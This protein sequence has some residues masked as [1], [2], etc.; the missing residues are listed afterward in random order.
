MQQA[1]QLHVCGTNATASTLPNPAHCSSTASDECV[2]RQ[3]H[4]RCVTAHLLPLSAGRQA[5]ARHRKTRRRHRPP[6]L[7]GLR[8]ASPRWSPPR[9]KNPPLQR[10]SRRCRLRLRLRTCPQ[11]T[12]IRRCCRHRR[13]PAANHLPSSCRCRCPGRQGCPARW[14]RPRCC[15]DSQEWRGHVRQT[16]SH[17]REAS[18][19]HASAAQGVFDAIMILLEDMANG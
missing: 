8:P 7:P 3:Q 2:I 10:R 9:R 17:Q 4:F 14:S 1:T 5:L 15:L 16:G 13:L 11:R 18:A 6:R 12:H 19:P